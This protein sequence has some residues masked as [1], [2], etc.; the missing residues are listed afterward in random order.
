MANTAGE[1]VAAYMREYYLTHSTR[2][3]RIPGAERQSKVCPKCAVDKDRS[4]YSVVAKGPRAGHLHG[5]CKTCNADSMRGSY[6]KK[7]KRDPTRY[8]LVEW[9]SKLKRLYGITPEDYN[10]MLADQGGGCALC[11]STSPL[12]GSRTYKRTQRTAFDVDHCH[13]TGRVRGLLCTRCNRL[14]GLANDSAD[15]ARRLVEYLTINLTT[16]EN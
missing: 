6:Q 13:K 5:R 2:P 1:K 14:V 16:K 7:H 10:R 11:G 12:T 8:R 4:E 9:P 15:T 3:R